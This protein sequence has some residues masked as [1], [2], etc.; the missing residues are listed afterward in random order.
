MDDVIAA[1]ITRSYGSLFN[2]S[3]MAVGNTEF[4]ERMAYTESAYNPVF[5]HEVFYKKT[6]HKKIKDAAK[7]Y[8]DSK[9]RGIQVISRHVAKKGTRRYYV[10][11]WIHFV[12]SLYPRFDYK[13]KSFYENI[14]KGEP[15]R[16]YVDVDLY[17][18]KYYCLPQGE[19]ISDERYA[20][21]TTML[22]GFVDEFIR[23][24]V[25]TLE[26]MYD[27]VF[28]T[29]VFYMDSSSKKK[30]SKH[31]VFHVNDDR[32]KFACSSVFLKL[33]TFLSS[34]AKSI[35]RLLSASEYPFHWPL[36]CFERIRAIANGIEMEEEEGGEKEP[37][38]FARVPVYIPDMTVFGNV[39]REFRINGSTKYGEERHMKLVK[40]LHRRTIDEAAGVSKL[41]D[42]VDTPFEK[43]LI[44][45]MLFTR[46]LICYVDQH[47]K[48]NHLLDFDLDESIRF[49]SV[50]GE[51]E[52]DAKDPTK[53]KTK[54]KS[55]SSSYGDGSVKIVDD[56]LEEIME[57]SSK[58]E[59]ELKRLFELS[60]DVEKQ[61]R[62][63]EII[64]QDI[65]SQLPHLYDVDFAP[66]RFTVSEGSC[67]LSFRTSSKYCEI[68]D[69]E[70]SHNHVYYVALLKSKCFYQR[71]WSPACYEKV[72]SYHDLK[73]KK[74][75][76]R[77]IKQDENVK[78]NREEEEEEEEIISKCKAATTAGTLSCKSVTRNLSMEIWEPIQDY[79]NLRKRLL[80]SYE[81]LKTREIRETAEKRK[82]ELELDYE[83][84]IMEET[85]DFSDAEEKASANLNDI[86][87]M[88]IFV[89]PDRV[90]NTDNEDESIRRY[91]ESLYCK[92]KTFSFDDLF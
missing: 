45:P 24:L 35:K 73:S 9:G 64:A 63:F 70:H 69:R 91:S 75:E 34:S 12:T 51:D 61:N 13:I 17:L 38:E 89:P 5:K 31:I 29:D 78:P 15:C 47:R 32:A 67:S 84:M 50:S 10:T 72:T 76:K 77:P 33:F 53:S 1:A 3:C 8:A 58:F 55:N 66:A 57:E 6:T 26:L 19:T 22:D 43:Y 4:K 59:G 36:D 48:I 46:L 27:D 25:S 2:A 71:C 40:H 37:G 30:Y 54:R 68:G 41:V 11:N 28:V 21:T 42:C 56:E 39:S 88:N 90:G 80:N 86:S 20:R 79:L 23:S 49:S 82:A 60:T 83:E 65:K 44:D 52:E 62:V 87:M 18:E 16:L 81:E 14:Y 92:A 85:G 7:E 74:K